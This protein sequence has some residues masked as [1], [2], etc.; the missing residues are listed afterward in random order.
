[1]LLLVFLGL[2]MAY[3][4]HQRFRSYFKT[5]ITAL[6]LFGLKRAIIL[7]FWQKLNK[8]FNNNLAGFMTTAPAGSWRPNTLN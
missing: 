3:V 5:K 2:L 4:K 8:L 7:H 6:S 1:M